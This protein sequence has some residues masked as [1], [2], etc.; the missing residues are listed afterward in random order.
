LNN[1]PSLLWTIRTKHLPQIEE[2]HMGH[3][4]STQLSFVLA[5]SVA[6]VLRPSVCV[7][8]PQ[9][10]A[11]IYSKK[12]EYLYQLV[13]HT[14]DILSSQKQGTVAGSKKQSAS[15]LAEDEAA[16]QEAGSNFL[17][18]ED[19]IKEGKDIDLDAQLDYDPRYHGYGTRGAASASARA[20][21]G[22]KQHGA[23]A[24]PMLAALLKE[25][26]GASFR[27]NSCAVHASGALVI[28]TTLAGGGIASALDALVSPAAAALAAHRSASS[29]AAGQGGGVDLD[30]NDDDDDDDGSF[31]GHDDYGGGG[32]DDEGGEVG[33]KASEAS[34]FAPRPS[35][36]KTRAQT[37]TAGATRGGRAP[38]Q[39]AAVDPWAVL[40]PHDPS[41]ERD[42]PSRPGRTWK[43]PPLVDE[44]A[45][46]PAPGGSGMA[47][48]ARRRQPKGKAAAAAAAASSSSSSSSAAKRAA[49]A[50]APVLG[51]LAFPEFEYVV[52]QQRA[53][54]AGARLASR[55]ALLAER[56]LASDGDDGALK[57][58]G[59]YDSD[60]DDDDDQRG[61][62]GGG[63]VDFG[64]YGGEYGGGDFGGGDDDGDDGHGFGGFEPNPNAAGQLSPFQR[65]LEDHDE[66]RPGL[67]LAPLA[68][69][70]A[71]S[72]GPKSYSELCRSH[73][74]SFMR[75]V[76]RYA[77]ESNLS[78][79]VGEWQDRL[80]PVLA[81]QAARR[82]FDIHEYGAEIMADVKV[83]AAG[84][85]ERNRAAAAKAL[86]KGTK[87]PVGEEERAVSFAAA[88]AGKA[89][90]EVARLF[91]AALQLSNN[92]NVVLHH[93]D[94]HGCT[95]CGP[96]DLS[97]EVVGAAATCQDRFDNYRAPSLHA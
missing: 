21:G 90:H 68:L 5:L 27:L 17:L 28:G 94:S 19:L 11:L 31:G 85:A 56:S 96:L 47:G 14:L 92:G 30:E 8:A 35:P 58:G 45:L 57:S 65:R 46:A 62:G 72:S 18:L 15:A 22:E 29:S 60:D 54:A 95:V 79:R 3:E 1:G 25:D 91:L 7:C 49:A 75:G 13:H 63:Q 83:V 20:A 82:E 4:C 78:K 71:F 89:P 37:G 61:G 69:D 41:G 48:N 43:V 93:D 74:A 10:S 53:Q 86:R 6:P 16:F 23:G 88:T 32:S 12:V 59:R 66:V 73:I 52:K 64:V 70:E 67:H 42:A 97:V 44:D 40:D 26:R 55:R 87:P 34:I 38:S 39:R 80:L 24:N 33:A 36:P 50:S 84:A 51:G 76:D 9:G 77:H 2:A 81:E